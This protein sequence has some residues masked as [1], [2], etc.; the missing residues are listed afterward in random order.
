VEKGSRPGGGIVTLFRAIG[1]EATDPDRWKAAAGVRPGGDPGGLAGI[2]DLPGIGDLRPAIGAPKPEKRLPIPS[3]AERE[4]ARKELLE[5]FAKDVAAA[6]TTQQKFELAKKWFALAAETYPR[7]PASCFTMM[8][9]AADVAASIGFIGGGYE[10]AEWLI[11][12]YEI[13]D[14][15]KVRIS[16][17]IKTGKSVTDQ[18]QGTLGAKWALA[19]A[20]AA[21]QAGRFDQI[22]ALI[23]VA[24]TSARASKDKDLIQF[25]VDKKKAL[26]EAQA[27]EGEIAT[28]RQALAAAPDD[29]AANT[30]LGLYLA[31]IRKSWRD[32]LP[33][34]AKSGEAGLAA[35]AKLDLTAPAEPAKQVEAGDAWWALHEAAKTGPHAAAYLAR[36]RHWYEQALPKLTGLAKLKVEKRVSEQ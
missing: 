19:L 23:Q 33:H 21:A 9:E 29:P 5:L 22:E 34:L 16:Y 12:R 28:V 13:D 8:T 18:E 4:Q 24:Q 2:G 15:L 14:P 20:D 32:A 10:T 3:A 27:A 7:E 1:S 30:K 31:G 11:E 6:K 17:C 26:E 36:A 35:A 25:V